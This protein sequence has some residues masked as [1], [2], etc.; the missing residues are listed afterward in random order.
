V[1]LEVDK[2]SGGNDGGVTGGEDYAGEA[3]RDGLVLLGADECQASIGDDGRRIA[4]EAEVG[5]D[6]A[7]K[8]KRAALE[9]ASGIAA[10]FALATPAPI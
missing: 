1:T 7:I 2:V 5:K 3:R 10:A 9:G 6:D 8:S 4:G